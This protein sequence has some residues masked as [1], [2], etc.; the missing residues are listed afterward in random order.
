MAQTRFTG[1][2]VSDNGFVG[3][4]TGGTTNLALTGTLSVAGT[5]TLTGAVTAPAGITGNLTGT[6]S[7]VNGAITAQGY[8]VAALPPVVVNGI[9][10]VTDANSGAGTVCFGKGTSWIDISTGVAVVA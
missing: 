9:I 1:P 4:F 10:V 8:L 2:V 7:A 3:A 5:S 6:A